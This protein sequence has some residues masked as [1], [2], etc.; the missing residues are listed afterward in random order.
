MKN[1]QKQ[2]TLEAL[3]NANI[4][5]DE[6]KKIL[7]DAMRDVV[8][9][10]TRANHKA[11]R[12]A[13]INLQHADARVMHIE[14]ALGYQSENH[15]KTMRKPQVGDVVYKP[16]EKEK[17]ATKMEKSIA[18]DNARKAESAKS[19]ADA[20]KDYERQCIWAQE[21]ADKAEAKRIKREAEK[22]MKAALRKAE[23]ERKA[24]EKAAEKAAKKEAYVE[25]LEAQKSF[26]LGYLP[27][28]AE[29]LVKELE[30]YNALV[31][32]VAEQYEVLWDKKLE[33]REAGKTAKAK[34]VELSAGLKRPMCS[35][36]VREAMAAKAEVEARINAVTKECS[37]A[38]KKGVAFSAER[39]AIIR[40]INILKK[41]GNA[42]VRPTIRSAMANLRRTER[43]KKIDEA[44]RMIQTVEERCKKDRFQI[45]SWNK[46]T[47][48]RANGLDKLFEAANAYHT[49]MKNG[50]E[51]EDAFDKSLEAVKKLDK[52]V[53]D[54]VPLKLNMAESRPSALQMNMLA[55]CMRIDPEAKG[56]RD[57]WISV[58]HGFF[59]TLK[60]SWK[61]FSNDRKEGQKLV[62]EF[63]DRVATLL[64]KIL[65]Y[66]PGETKPVMYNGLYSSASH[67]KNEKLV[68]C[69]EELMKLHEIIV[70]FGLTKER[71]LA[72]EVT[73]SE[74]WKM[75]ANLAR[76]IAFAVNLKD[77]TPIY[78]HN[79]KMVPDPKKNY[80]VKNGLFIGKGKNGQCYEYRDDYVAVKMGDGEAL[81]I[82]EMERDAFQGGGTGVKMMCAYAEDALHEAER[83]R[84]RKALIE[85]GT[86]IICG[87]G[88]FKFDKLY[89]SFEE[90]AA[91][92][93]AMAERYPGINRVYALRES[94]ELEDNEK[95]RRVS[96]SLLQQLVVASDAELNELVTPTV[97]SLCYKKT[98]EGIFASLAELGI[99]ADKRSAFARLVF[100]CPELITNPI[101]Q[102]IAERSWTAK[103]REAMGNKFR[104]DGQYPYILQDPVAL[105]EVWLLGVDPDDPD[106]GVL[107]AGEASV[108]G[109][110]EGKKMVAIRYPANFFTAKT[111]VC[112][113]MK[114]LF[115]RCGNVAILSIHDDILIIQD[116]DVDGDEA[117]FFYNELLIELVE[118]MIRVVKPPVVIFEHDGKVKRSMIGTEKELIHRMYASLHAAKEFDSVGRYA[119]LARDCAY[120]CRIALRLGKQASDAGDY[121]EAKKQDALY[122][123]YIL[124]MAAASTGAILAIDQVKGVAVDE[125]LIGWLDKIGDEVK[126]IMVKPVVEVVDG[127]EVTKNKYA[128]PF[129]QPF[130]KG[131]DSIETLEPNM[132]V[133]T[134]ALAMFVNVTAGSWGITDNELYTNNGKLSELITDDR[135]V[136][137]RVRQAV[138][139]SGVLTELRANYFNRKTQKVTTKGVEEI[140]C[141]KKI[142]NLI[143]AKMPV[144]QKDLLLMY[145]R[146]ACT[147][148]FRMQEK[149]IPGRKAAYCKMVHDSLIRQALSTKWFA[150]EFTPG[151]EV[152]HE[153]TDEE[154]ITSVVNNAVIDALELGTKGNGIEADMKASYAKFVLSVFVEELIDN[155][156]RNRHKVDIRHF[157]MSDVEYKACQ[158]AEF[159]ETD[160]D[161]LVEYEVEYNYYD[162][163]HRSVND[164]TDEEL[165][166]M[167]PEEEDSGFWFSEPI[168]G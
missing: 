11:V 113:P 141:D 17:E 71:V 101:V 58:E 155:V 78:L 38:H 43:V 42:A 27:Q 54:G 23:T 64:D 60:P 92:M 25:R 81:A 115:G 57:E 47:V 8:E 142:M 111:V 110:P 73:G 24:A 152:G 50:E 34:V 149:T 124:W 3:A 14:V 61:L 120:L 168:F 166:A 4:Q 132:L 44:I 9:N 93:D 100:E 31:A 136:T 125:N 29:E 45:P 146:N 123:K 65:V 97:N 70:W 147:L 88:C 131:D 128:A 143:A 87:D 108:V 117:G 53:E 107:K 28:E 163:G 99:P 32:T 74:I 6:A 39:K 66:K 158:D 62:S 75:R 122:R 140:N 145:W 49:G 5:L 164:L 41:H 156:R 102:K 35:A 133:G 154:K 135:H 2:S 150:T 96:R 165:A 19:M 86:Y 33:L 167:A 105:F 112:K 91:R 121:I 139:T 18:V 76:P 137:T 67:Q 36:K 46:E 79:I 21:K 12:R 130:V 37:A 20:M 13:E 26:A 162:D 51:A 83:K 10:N 134:D 84:G 69:K 22:A 82:E 160:F 148:E 55:M 7:E 104:V 144:G 119:N 80:F 77:G 95:V 161:V 116:G 90:F 56:V 16:T 126:K 129:T 103:K 127:K 72:T 138:V 109:V 63:V 94:E 153:F 48:L 40:Q 15:N 30:N 151:Y 59:T 52:M 1:F 157:M 89:D 159:E 98:Y 68:S 85:D 114:E 106:L 118:R